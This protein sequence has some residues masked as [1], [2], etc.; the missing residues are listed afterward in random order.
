MNATTASAHIPD[1]HP[2]RLMTVLQKKEEDGHY[3]Q[4]NYWSLNIDFKINNF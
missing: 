1:M 3:C 4:V 2:A